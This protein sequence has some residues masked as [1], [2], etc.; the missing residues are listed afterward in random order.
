VEVKDE[1]GTTVQK[2]TYDGLSRRITKESDAKVVHTYWSDRWKPLEERIDSGTTAA[3]SYLWGERPGHRDELVLRDR[4][5]NEDGTLDERLYATMDYFN[6]TSI[7]DT[8]GNVLERYAYA[9]FGP[10]RVMAPNFTSR[11]NSLYDWEFGF[12]GQLRDGETGW[13][14]YGYRFYVPELGRWINRDPIGEDGGWNLYE[15]SANDGIGNVDLF[16][17]LTQFGCNEGSTCKDG[18]TAQI[19]RK[20]GVNTSSLKDDRCTMSPNIYGFVE[21]CKS[22]DDCYLTC[23]AVKESCDDQFLHELNAICKRQVGAHRILC[24]EAAR[25]YWIGVSIGGN[26][27]AGDQGFSHL[28]ESACT[29]MCNCK[30][31]EFPIVRI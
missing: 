2:N 14:N 26:N 27:I 17:L 10:R 5:T 11:S 21:A 25:A 7:L 9:A 8:S 29:C 22:H 30:E 3:R 20:P 16:G 12:Q 23:G 18:S 28:Q 6:G 31:E 13:Y 1:N 15:F 4:D 24:H 19:E